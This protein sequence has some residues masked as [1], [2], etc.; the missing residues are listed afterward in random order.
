MAAISGMD[1]IGCDGF[2]YYPDGVT[3]RAPYGANK[4]NKLIKQEYLLPDFLVD[5]NSESES[6]RLYNGE[7]RPV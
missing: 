2:R 1:V 6:T 7:T 5:N 3:Y 4:L